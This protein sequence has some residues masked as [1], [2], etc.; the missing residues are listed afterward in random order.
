MQ[1]S[2]TKYRLGLSIIGLFTLVILVIVLVQASATKQDQQTYN[3]ANNI[4]TKLNN[5]TYSGVAPDSL[6]RV[7][8]TNVPSTIT[9]TKTGESSYQFC[10]TYK[11]ASSDFSAS[12]VAQNVMT[13]GFSGSG[14]NGNNDQSSYN[15]LPDLEI[16]PAHHKGANCQ[17]VNLYNYNTPVYNSQ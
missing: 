10:A 1:R 2:L 16:N 3:E 13:N 15:N 11:Q 6:S 7:G 12:D 17:T 4:A 8:I 5:D 14:D 9:Y